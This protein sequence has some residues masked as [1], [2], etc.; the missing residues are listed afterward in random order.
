MEWIE[1]MFD[2]HHGC[3][4]IDLTI[5]MANFHLGY[6]SG[7]RRPSIRCAAG[8]PEPKRYPRQ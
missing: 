5:Y 4:M 2:H 1:Q 6:R 3:E 8:I 7:I